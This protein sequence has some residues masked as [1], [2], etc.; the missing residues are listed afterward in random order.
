[1]VFN[2]I[3]QQHR[4]IAECR[5][6]ACPLCAVQFDQQVLMAG[7]VRTSRISHRMLAR[8]PRREPTI[9]FG[10]AFAQPIESAR[11]EYGPG[12]G[13]EIGWAINQLE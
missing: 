9:G 3:F 11:P 5:P 10:K 7:S 4:G 6:L 2:Q 1:M 12:L 13:D 8:S